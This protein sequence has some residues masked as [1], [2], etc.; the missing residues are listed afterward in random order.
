MPNHVPFGVAQITY[1]ITLS[2]K[3]LHAVLAEQANAFVICL[4]D[5]IRRKSFAYC[6]QRHIFWATAGPPRCGSDSLMDSGNVF[7]DGQR[8]RVS[9]LTW[10]DH[11]IAV[12]GAGSLGSPA[13]VSGNQ[14]ISTA[15][16]TITIIPPIT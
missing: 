3:L 13:A 11:I 4:T 6:H 14:I 12:G 9:G 8:L 7:G 5:P 16:P 2:S 10:S 15:R 1:C